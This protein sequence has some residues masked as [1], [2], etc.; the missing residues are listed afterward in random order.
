MAQPWAGPLPFF[1]RWPLQLA[2]LL[3]GY[4]YAY[5]ARGIPSALVDVRAIMTAMALLLQMG[6]V[7]ILLTLATRGV[8]PTAQACVK[9]ATVL[10]PATAPSA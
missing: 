1:W 4:Y 6:V 5:R 8:Q 2:L 9:W 3:H 10:I 7:A